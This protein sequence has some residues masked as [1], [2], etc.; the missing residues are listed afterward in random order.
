MNLAKSIKKRIKLPVRVIK[1]LL[2]QKHL[3]PGQLELLTGVPCSSIHNMSRKNL[4]KPSQLTRCY[5]YP[6]GS[7]IESGPVFIVNDEK[8]VEFISRYNP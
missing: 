7:D 4:K 3:S 6:V 1:Q 5:P 8:C 2:K